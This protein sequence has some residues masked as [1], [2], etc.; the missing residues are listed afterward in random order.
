M[1]HEFTYYIPEGKWP[2]LSQP[3]NSLLS[4]MG[5][6][7][8]SGESDLLLLPGGSDWGIRPLRDI[9][10]REAYD[11]YTRKGQKILGICRGA[12][13]HCLLSGGTLIDHLPDWND[14]LMHTTITGDWKG[15][16]SY[17]GVTDGKNILLTNSRHHQGFI[18]IP[19]S[20]TV[21]RSRDGLAEGGY[22]EK[23]FW[24][25]WHPEHSDMLRTAAQEKFKTDF[26]G[27][28]WK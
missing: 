24:V 6:R 13:V 8:G 12:Q 14:Q 19:N 25:Q 10:E 17:H 22:D 3:Y 1:R 11:H 26:N 23:C 28:F 9:A 20:K 21:W 27:W 18:D 4:S 15:Q 2:M 16:S 5:G 7:P